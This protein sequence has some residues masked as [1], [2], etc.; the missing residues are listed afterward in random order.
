MY[1][2]KYQPSHDPQGSPANKSPPVSS[3]MYPAAP[4]QNHGCSENRCL[5]PDR[6]PSHTIACKYH[7]DD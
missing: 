6:I 5:S 7:E 2:I 4:L 3:A 1:I